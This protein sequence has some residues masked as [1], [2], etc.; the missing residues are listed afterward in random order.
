MRPWP[1]AQCTL[2]G[3]W[4]WLQAAQGGGAADCALQPQCSE[5]L[6]LLPAPCC[7]AGLWVILGA[8]AAAGLL[9]LALLWAWRAHRRR[10]RCLASAKQADGA[11]MPGGGEN[12]VALPPRP[13]QSDSRRPYKPG[14]A[15][16]QTVSMYGAQVRNTGGRQRL[17][18]HCAWIW[19]RERHTVCPCLLPARC[20]ADWRPPTGGG[21]GLGAAQQRPQPAGWRQRRRQLRAPAA[22]RP[23]GGGA[24]GACARAVRCAGAGGCAVVPRWQRHPCGGRA[25][26]GGAA[27][28]ADGGGVRGRA[29]VCCLIYSI[30]SEFIASTA[31]RGGG[32]RGSRSAGW[33]G[34]RWKGRGAVAWRLAGHAARPRCVCI[35]P[36]LCC[37]G[38]ALGMLHSACSSVLRRGVGCTG[39]RRRRR[40]RRKRALG[41]GRRQ[42]AAGAQQSE[43]SALLSASPACSYEGAARSRCARSFDAQRP[44]AAPQTCCC[45]RR[46][47]CSRLERA[48]PRLW[49]P[50]IAAPPA[51]ARQAPAW[52]VPPLHAPRPT[53]PLRL[54]RPPSAPSTPPPER[55][56]RLAAAAGEAP[57]LSR[58]PRCSCLRA[59]PSCCAA[60]GACCSWRCRQQWRQTRRA[61]AS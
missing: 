17:A 12:G 39:R 4:R 31:A 34:R 61:A 41:P 53:A 38:F 15:F 29:C 48:S 47:A 30:Y 55:R 24:S 58:P 7:P 13:R 1:A 36:D 18:R 43:C 27:G 11:G 56:Q 9:W 51:L 8:G 33:G 6:P 44:P 32:T 35:Q 28:G 23:A 50:T 60:C 14:V 25:A 21:G 19:R 5:P 59:T 45:Q 20:P 16:K 49:R 2:G 42:A 37:S 10:R 26:G 54:R 3:P 52:P 57:G 40:R 46:V 22:G